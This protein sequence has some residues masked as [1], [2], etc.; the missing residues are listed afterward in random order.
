MLIHSLTSLSY[1][2]VNASDSSNSDVHLTFIPWPNVAFH[3]VCTNDAM[4]CVRNGQT[5][6]Q[7][8]RMVSK[9]INTQKMALS[10]QLQFHFY[11][12]S[13]QCVSVCVCLCVELALVCM[14]GSTTVLKTCRLQTIYLKEK[15][16]RKHTCKCTGSSVVHRSISL[17]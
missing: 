6:Q 14:Y 13:H 7:S 8:W 11:V 17:S 5:C 4:C 1:A 15:N 12:Y 3:I 16:Q 9:H 10:E 2:N